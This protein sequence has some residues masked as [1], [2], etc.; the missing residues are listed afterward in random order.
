MKFGDKVDSK[1]MTQGSPPVVLQV[2]PQGFVKLSTPEELR[3]FEQMMQE[4]HG[5]RVDVS[6]SGLNACETCSAG[7]SDDCGMM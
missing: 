2:Q 1:R 4:L 3:D 5:S 7:C 6:K